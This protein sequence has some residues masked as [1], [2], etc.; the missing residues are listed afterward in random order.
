MGGGGKKSA[1]TSYHMIPDICPV[2]LQ[3]TTEVEEN[4]F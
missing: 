4:H 2:E 3:N 1:R